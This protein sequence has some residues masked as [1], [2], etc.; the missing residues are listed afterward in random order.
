MMELWDE[1]CQ[2]ASTI[3]YKNEEDSM[4]WQF[5]SSGQFSVQSLYKIVN[6]RGIQQVFVPS[7]WDI[8]I[9]PRVQYFLWLLSKNKVLTRDNLSKRRK[10]EDPTCLFCEEKESVYH[11]FFEC[12]VAKQLW[13]VLSN[14]FG[15]QLISSFEDVGKFW[16][17][18]KHNGILNLF[19]SAAVWCLWKLRNDLCFQRSSWKSMPI[20]IFQ[21]AVMA[22]KWKILYPEEK[23]EVI[24]QKVKMFKD[25][26]NQVLWMQWR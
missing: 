24:S 26:A 9:P 6:F 3:I 19:T 15:I 11:L 25:K 13:T 2:I 7:I 4:V 1:V 21:V 14:I 16:L 5:S 23:K 18:N 10:V 8:K 20:L 22:E 17:S 12:A